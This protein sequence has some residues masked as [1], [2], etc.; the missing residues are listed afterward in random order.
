MMKQVRAYVILLLCIPHACYTQEAQ[1][2]IILPLKVTHAMPTLRIVMQTCLEI[3]K[4][5]LEFELNENA[6]VQEVQHITDCLLG[7]LIRL[8]V[9]AHHASYAYSHEATLDSQDVCYLIELI[10]HMNLSCKHD[11]L[12]F[13]VNELIE[14]IKELLQKTL[15]K[16]RR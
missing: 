7:K 8:C 5:L 6:T 13:D 11:Q 4:D 1:S 10:E 15:Q 14:Y 16:K 12:P 3:Y 9:Y 2:T